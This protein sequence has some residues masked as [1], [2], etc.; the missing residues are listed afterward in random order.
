MQRDVPRFRGLSDF[1]HFIES[2]GQLRRIREKV[3]V[4][5]EITE[6]HRRVLE[7]HGPALLFEQPVKADGGPSDMPLLTNLFG[8]TERIAWGM[9]IVPNRLEELGALMAELRAPRPPNGIRDAFSKLPLARAALATRLR[10]RAVAPVQDRVTMGPDID[11]ARLPIQ[12]CWPG[13]PAPLIT[14]PLVITVP[15]DSATGDQ[16]ENVG[17]YR[18]QVLGRDRAIIRWLAHRGGARHHQQWKAIGRDMPV[19]IVIGADPATI[20]AAV[21]PLPET[22]SELRFAGILRGER[23]DLAPCLTVPLAVPAEAEIV[24]EGF[25]SATETAPEGPY[26]DHTGY[27]NSIEAFPVM[28]VTAITSRNQPVYLSTFTGRPPDEPSQIGEALNRLFVPLIRQQFPEVT[29][30]WLPPEACSYRIAVAAIKKRYP[31]QARRLMLGLWSMLPQF[32]YTKLLIVV[33]EDIDIRDWRAVMWAVSTRSDS[34]RDLVTLTDTPIDYL[35]FASPKSGLGGK[36]G[37]DATTK[38]PPETDRDWGV[39][40][41]MDP[42]VAARVDA[43]WPSLGLSGTPAR[44]PVLT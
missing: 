14:W 30:C 24:I 39:P 5:H 7:A 6:I 25:V 11:L 16:D 13:E 26:G 1:L 27:Y 9:G 22:L 41:A 21:M 19:A 2:R 33:D 36:L 38:I 15:P 8:T 43:M 10:T 34:S 3:S 32:S 44:A 17:V 4:V 29:D 28:R 40:L 18:M 35:D 31:G 42:A 37:I 23:P 20:L 12:I